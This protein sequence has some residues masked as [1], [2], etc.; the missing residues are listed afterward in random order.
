MFELE[1]GSWRA[2]IGP[3]VLGGGAPAA[4]KEERVNGPDILKHPIGTLALQYVDLVHGGKMDEAMRLATTDAQAKWKA[5]PASER[6]ESTAFRRKMLPTRAD[7]MAA[8]QDRRRVDHRRRCPR[9]AECRS[10]RTEEQQ[11]GRGLVVVHDG[12][13]PIREGE[14]AVA[15]R[16][17]TDQDIGIHADS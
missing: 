7:L 1:G 17:M 14:R 12:L 13:H 6:A 2:S 16:A 3:M 15:A 5:E 10:D 8:A 11:A 9:D 4:T